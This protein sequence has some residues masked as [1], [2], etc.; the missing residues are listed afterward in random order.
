MK[1]LY[2]RIHAYLI[3]GNACQLAHIIGLGSDTTRT[4]NS[5]ESEIRLRRFWACYLMHCY[6][7]ESSSLFEPTAEVK[8]MRLPWSEEDFNAGVSNVPAVKLKMAQSN[9]GVFSEM[10]KGMTLW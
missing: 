7:S 3:S 5:L 4:E 6:N 1:L 8:N 10:I 9:G 2:K